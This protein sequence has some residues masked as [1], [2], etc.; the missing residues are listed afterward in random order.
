MT[1]RLKPENVVHIGLRDIDEDEWGTLQKLKIKCYTPDH[2][3]MYGI[4][5][6]MR[7]SI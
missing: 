5:E 1:R 4:G 2:V 3:D 7:Q 6:V